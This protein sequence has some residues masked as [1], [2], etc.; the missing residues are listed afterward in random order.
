MNQVDPKVNDG[1]IEDPFFSVEQSANYLGLAGVVKHPEQAV[2]ALIRK[3]RLQAVR[4]GGRWMIRQSW[5]ETYIGQHVQE[6]VT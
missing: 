4:I 1:P 6:A 3:R 5:L 2:R